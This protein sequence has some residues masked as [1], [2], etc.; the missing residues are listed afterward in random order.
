MPQRVAAFRS[1]RQQSGGCAQRLGSERPGGGPQ[2][3]LDRL[4]PVPRVPGKE[5][6][7]PIARQRDR[8]V[9]ARGHRHKV[10]RN[11]R[12]VGKW[13]VQVPRDLLDQI[14]PGSVHHSFMVVAAE[15]AGHEPG[16]RQLVVPILMEADRRCHHGTCHEFRHGGDHSAR[17]HPAAQKRPQ[18]DVAAQPDPHRLREALTELIDGCPVRCGRVTGVL[19]NR[20]V[21][22]LPDRDAPRSAHQE[23]AGR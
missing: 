13:L 22:V 15:V 16:V 3:V 18:R 23:V 4:D 6:V 17:V 12:R 11:H 21:P 9:F 19:G 5:L 1:I 14:R 10:R 2:P 7:P 20:N 8:H